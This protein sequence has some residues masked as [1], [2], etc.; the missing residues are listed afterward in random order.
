MT[1]ITYKYFTC[2]KG[3][4]SGI[5]SC[6][7]L[8]AHTALQFL[9]PQRASYIMNHFN[10]LGSIQP[11]WPNHSTIISLLP[12]VRSSFSVDSTDTCVMQIFSSKEKSQGICWELNQ[13]P[14]DSKSN[15]V[16]L[17]HCVIMYSLYNYDNEHIG[18][19]V[20]L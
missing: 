5:Q 15:T 12:I 17:S 16:P 13:L 4:G 10:S 14:L 9:P 1:K 2:Y 18:S 6:I 20:W 7:Y 3:K 19:Q 8:S 11:L